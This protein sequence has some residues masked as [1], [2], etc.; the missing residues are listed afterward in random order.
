[1][2]GSVPLNEKVSAKSLVQ[3]KHAFSFKQSDMQGIMVLSNILIFL[4]NPFPLPFWDS[5]HSSI[6]TAP[7]QYDW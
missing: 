2:Q 4:E 5:F 3:L 7:I 1:M 6:W